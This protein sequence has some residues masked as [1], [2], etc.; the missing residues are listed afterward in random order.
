MGVE[1]DRIQRPSIY[2]PATIGDI[3]FEVIQKALLLLE[4]DDLVSASLSCRA[5]RQAAV[6]LILA[7][8][9][10]FYDEQAIEK[11]V[12]GMQLKS[13]V[14]GFKQYSIKRLV[15]IM[16]R[17]GIEHVRVM[18][19]TVAPTLSTLRLQFD[20]PEEEDEESVLNCYKVLE[21]FFS[22][23]LQIRCLRLDYFD[24]GDD[25]TSFTPTIK[26]GFGRLKA[27]KLS[28]CLGNLMM[29]AELAPIQNLST[30]NYI[31]VP[32][33]IDIISAIAMKSRSLKDIHLYAS[34]DSWES[35]HKIVDYCRE[36]EE[37]TLYD[38]SRYQLLK[39]SEFVAIASLPRL[40]SLELSD[41][42]IDVGA[43]S[44][45]AR[46]KRLRHLRGANIKLSSDVVR[47]IGRN[48]VTLRCNLGLNGL[49]EIVE[50]CPNLET[51]AIV[52]KDE[53]GNLVDGETLLSA[54]GLIKRGLKKLTNLVINDWEQS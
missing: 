20:D 51:L 30:F 36:L 9:I 17:I 33:A 16:P 7:Q 22:S 54:A 32:D 31:G 1:Y 46:C 6:E 5:W 13:I 8:S 27:L 3:P 12:C 52:V 15:L 44:P 42:D 50:F 25:P 21:A 40:K 18:A 26:D 45:L 11:F 4:D 28:N 47:A 35:I 53:E 39:N 34:F 43:V 37:V 38:F 41:C 19:K 14:F 24:F 49:E 10:Y 23:C 29:I 48:L 2:H